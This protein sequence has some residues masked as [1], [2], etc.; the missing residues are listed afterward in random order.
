[1]T[2]ALTP[3]TY[4]AELERAV[5]DTY[6]EPLAFVMMAWPWGE[7]GTPLARFKGPDANQT[8]FL[9]DLGKDIRER[10]FDGY[11]PV[12][13][14]RKS[15]ASAH[16][17]GKTALGAMLAWFILSTRPDSIGTV[18]AGTYQQLEERTWAEIMSWGRMCKTAHW[19][20]IQASG[21]FAKDPKRCEK[22]KV[23]PK[24]ATEARAQTF[25]GQHAVTSTSWFLFDEASLIPE[26]VWTVAEGGLTD[27]EPMHF[28]W[29]QMERSAGEFYDVCFGEASQKNWDARV[30]DGW[31]SAFTNKTTLAEWREKY[32]EDSDWYRVR[33][34][35]LPPRASELQFIGQDL[36]D[37]ARRR[38]HIALPDEPLV[39]GY[40]AANGGLA[41]HCLWPRR[42]LDAKSIPPIF[43]PGDTPRDAV[44]AKIIEL[45]SDQR[46]GRRAA[47]L[48]GDQAFGAVIL[49]RVRDFG[50]TNVFE[51]NFGDT[52]FDKHYL[53]R[54]SEMWGH[55][56]EWM[57]LGAIPD[58]H[59]IYQPFMDPGFHHRNGK[60]VL[61]SKADMAARRVKSPDGPDAL[62]LSFAQPVAPVMQPSRTAPE[63]AYSPWA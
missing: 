4:E 40:D 21:I 32:G 41:K 14:I 7:P 23:T 52:S 6:A 31:N 11:T 58:D 5:A 42:G 50:Y 55:M 13:P 56:K 45:M 27:G 10:R 9:R 39:W 51:V 37:G 22:W 33:V 62:C 57:R 46:P 43:L 1:M 18:T 25:A 38:D 15:I 26:G 29:G 20:D 30:F 44:V 54:R 12:A 16:G 63:I 35:G 60:L 17:T 19:F 2:A 61:E 59:K 24:T 36:I 48:F 53:N 28:A 34:L 3:D 47:A 8:K 49:Q